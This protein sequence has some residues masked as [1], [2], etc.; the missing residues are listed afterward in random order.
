[1]AN[2]KIELKPELAELLRDVLAGRDP[3]LLGVLSE[4]G[5]LHLDAEQADRVREP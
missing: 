5:S 3:D 1:M 4:D 2:V